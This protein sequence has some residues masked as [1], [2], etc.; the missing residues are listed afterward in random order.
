MMDTR[1]TGS[2]SLED[3]LR[4]LEDRAAIVDLLSQYA[5]AVDACRWNEWEAC[6]AEDARAEFPFGNYEGRRGIGA[7]CAK[8]LVGFKGFE[9]LFGNVEIKIDGDRATGRNKAWIACVMD[10]SKPHEHFDNGGYYQ[11]E[12]V[13]SNEGWRVKRV[14]LKIV[15]LSR[16][17]SKADPY[18]RPILPR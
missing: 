15:W 10:D 17:A 6:F 9:H 3:R 4:R 18:S 8:N 5:N 14:Q 11:W 7:W 1:D 12:F 2:P 13:R 16:E